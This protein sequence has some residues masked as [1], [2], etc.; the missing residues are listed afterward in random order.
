MTTDTETA[1]TPAQ[2]LESAEADIDRIYAWLD[3][4]LTDDEEADAIRDLKLAIQRRN[5]A[6]AMLKMTK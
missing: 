3:T 1:M 2:L 5:V 6:R 4:D